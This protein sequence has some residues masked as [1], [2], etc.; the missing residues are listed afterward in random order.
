MGIYDTFEQ[1]LPEM[2][3]VRM[4]YDLYLK[5]N[6]LNKTAEERLFD[7]FSFIS[8][9]Y[10]FN[11]EKKTIEFTKPNIADAL[12]KS[13]NGAL[14]YDVI[15]SIS[16]R[17]RYREMQDKAEFSS[18]VMN[19][20]YED[21]G[22]YDLETLVPNAVYSSLAAVGLIKILVIFLLLSES[23]ILNVKRQTVEKKAEECKSYALKII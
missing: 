3:N 14:M 15:S 23:H 18:F 5:E 10:H 2:K 9:A 11:K 17:M 21:G 12:Q 7:Y 8:T 20:I 19:E 16:Q 4:Q 1:Y 6:N 13:D 22:K